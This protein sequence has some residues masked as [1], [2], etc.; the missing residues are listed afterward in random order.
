MLV[1]SDLSAY[2]PSDKPLILGVGNFDGIHLGH[3]ELIRHVLQQ[4]SLHQGMSGLLT[5]R[6]H[7]H[8]VLYPQHQPRLLTAPG[9]KLF[10]FK[11]LGIEICFWLD[12][13]EPFSQIRANEFIEDILCRQLKVREVCMGYNA[14]F[15]F[16]REGDS[17]MMEVAA[18]HCG[19]E[20]EKIEPV[21][22][23]GKAVSSSRIRALILEGNLEEAALCLGRPFRMAGKVVAGDHRGKGLGFPTANIEFLPGLLPPTGVYPVRMRLLRYELKGAEASTFQCEGEGSSVWMD[24]ILNLGYRPTFQAEHFESGREPIPE[25]HLLDFQGDLYGKTVEISF[26]PKIREERRF[27]T[28]ESLQAQIKQ[29]V[30]KARSFL[31]KAGPE[32]GF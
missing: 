2:R 19:F 25:V 31:A 7:P 12:F 4:A 10:L 9:Y 26:Y 15:G 6:E 32:H 28:P 17:S 1:L 11:Q 13:T 29:D 5:F 27:E 3:Q 18:K 14:R 24:G 21:E 23:G 16:R 22:A 8:K 30:T 20:F